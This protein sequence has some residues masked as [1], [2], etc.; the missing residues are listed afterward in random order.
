MYNIENEENIDRINLSL[1]FEIKFQMESDK[2]VLQDITN[3]I[4]EYIEDINNISDLHMPNLITYITNI[5]REHIVY[6]KFIALNNYDS[7]YQSIY[8][9][10]EMTDDYFV[11][12]QTV[13]E[14]INVNTLN[15]DLPD[16]EFTIVS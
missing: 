15:N 5:Y 6:I 16:I 14:F 2:V 9:N 7:L 4:K 3:S 10:P 8:K 13:P 12:T 11:E 1:K